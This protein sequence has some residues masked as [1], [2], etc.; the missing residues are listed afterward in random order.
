MAAA[1][2][3]SLAI[4]AVSMVY[5][6]QQARKAKKKAKEDADARKGFE[7]S[8]AGESMALPRIYGRNKVAG[9]RVYHNVKSNYVHANYSGPNFTAGMTRNLNFGHNG[10]LYVQ[11]AFAQ[12]GVHSIIDCTIDGM[13]KS[14]D[15]FVKTGY[16]VNL[17]P[18]GSQADPM[19]AANFPERNSAVFSDVAYASM[20]FALNRDDPQYGGVPE[21][22]FYVEGAEVFDI[23]KVGNTYVLAGAKAYTTNPALCLLDYLTSPTFGRGLSLDSID[24]ESFYYG[25]RVCEKPV[26]LVP[27]EGRILSANLG[28]YWL[29]LYEC[30]MVI[31]TSRP[32]RDNIIDMLSCMGDADMVW[33]GGKYKLQLQYPADLGQ[34]K[35]AGQVTDD[36]IARNTMTVQYPSASDRMNF[37][38][39]KFANEANDFQEDSASWPPKGGAI[40]L[41]LL[42][43]DNNIPLEKSYSE[44]GI[45]SYYHALAKAEELV[46]VSR[47]S[48]V[49]NFKLILS[50][51][52]YEPGDILQVNSEVATIYDEY[53]KIQE[54]SIEDDSTANVTAVKFD[55]NQLAWNAKDDEIIPPRNQY[56]FSIKPVDASTIAF[57]PNPVEAVGE[58]LGMLVW[59]AP[60]PEVP[61]SYR[62]SA[63]RIGTL[64]YVSLGTTNTNKIE[65][66]SLKAGSYEFAVQAVYIRGRMASVSLSMPIAI[67][68]LPAP[69]NVVYSPLATAHL[70]S[71]GTVK[72]DVVNDA[73]VAY[74]NVY[75]YKV[76]DLDANFDPIWSAV[77]NSVKP[78]FI[79]PGLETTNIIVGV[80][81]VSKLGSE[82]SLGLSGT[83]TI[84]YPTPPTPT[85]LTAAIAGDQKESVRLNWTI[86]A[87]RAN[88]S[89]YSDHMVTVVYRRRPSTSPTWQYVGETSTTTYLDVATE[90]GALEY[91]VKFTSRRGASGPQTT[92]VQI[93]VNFYD[94]TDNTP[95]PAPYSLVATALFS[96]FMLEWQIPAYTIGRGHGA[97]LIYAA[98]WPEGQ[99]QPSFADVNLVASV[100]ISDMYI[101][102]S[103]LG[104]R[105]VFW[106]KEMSVD[107][108]VST[109]FAGPSTAKTGLIGTSDL[110]DSIIEAQNIK[111]GGISNQKMIPGLE[112]VTYVT[113]PL[114]PTVKVS[115]LI[116]WQRKLY[117]WD[118]A[119]TPNKYTPVVNAG[120][121]AGQIANDQIA[122]A[123][124]T[125]AKFASGIEPVT[126]VAGAVLPTVK[127][128]NTILFMGV[129][130]KW[131]GAAYTTQVLGTNAITADNIQANS[132]TVGKV[133]AGAIN[134]AE[135]AAGAITTSK[136]AA[137]AITAEKIAVGAITAEKIAADTITG[138]KIAANTITASEIATGAIVADKI[139]AGA[140]TVGSA[141]IADGAIRNALIANLAVDSAKIANA[142][143]GTIKIIDG[144]ITNAKISGVIRSDATDIYGRP[145]WSLDRSGLLELNSAAGNFRRDM[146]ANY[147]RYWYISTGVLVIEIGELT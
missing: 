67:N 137:V 55:P 66:F 147:D 146:R 3:V 72:W 28:A 48:V 59:T 86:P 93:Q 108:G 35:V 143:V 133:A 110:G 51:L 97:T 64:E 70:E 14:K 62:V 135:L 126:V 79:L 96:N 1:T 116:S 114:L 56:D 84:V 106:A 127:S 115:N 25:A 52:F 88:G 61:V 90:Y 87:T 117:K 30:N 6:A 10:C 91:A 138:D 95:P 132:I 98:E 92:G 23:V 43:E 109:A 29:P 134:T 83:I 73:R 37:C 121:M 32:V 19:M 31:D 130:Y 140:I 104:K 129:L 41:A 15:E 145:L 75:V 107:R 68:A 128:T 141:A 123:A 47:V 53:L 49:Y 58:S 103:V 78:F 27:A 42:A 124:L 94:A 16:R 38:T 85:G 101:F 139:A 40:N 17:F 9:A 80:T 18:K 102:P 36:D 7:I 5:Q 57:L 21:V 54:I 26:Q 46:R 45:V 82:S 118:D 44:A 89:S 39:V 144:A 60:G 24:L 76:G 8:V 77:G 81:S 136:I 65:I 69:T 113:T 71:A 100:E 74:Y 50:G 112:A 22:V 125:T 111:D 2:L 142:S 120:E 12:G 122:D 119:V 63:R 131:N 4:T 33:S 20:V 105:M 11:Q 34:V 99:P 13:E